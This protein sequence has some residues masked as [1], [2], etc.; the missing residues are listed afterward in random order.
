MKNVCFCLNI[1]AYMHIYKTH[2]YHSIFKIFDLT[3]IVHS[4][5][6]QQNDYLLPSSFSF[7]F[8]I[9]DHENYYNLFN[10]IFDR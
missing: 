3:T 9:F 2:L 4:K 7:R 8:N 5:Q 10:L 6:Q 1:S